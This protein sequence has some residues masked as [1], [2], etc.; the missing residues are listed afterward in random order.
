LIQQLRKCL[1]L[2]HNGKKI[3]V[4]GPA[5]Y[6]VLVQVGGDPRARCRTL[7]DSKVEAVRCTRGPEYAHRVLG[8]CAEGGQ[9]VVSQLGEVRDVTVWADQEMSG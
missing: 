7:V 2:T 8:Q 3:G 9:L 1:G 5:R 4:A 6:H